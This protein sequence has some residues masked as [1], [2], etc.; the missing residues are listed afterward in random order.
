MRFCMKVGPWTKWAEKYS[1][2]CYLDNRCHG[3]QKTSSEL[4][5][6][7]KG[8]GILTRR[9]LAWKKCCRGCMLPWQPLCCHSAR[10]RHSG[11]LWCHSDILNASPCVSD[12]T[13]LT[14]PSERVKALV[15]L[16]Y[17]YVI[18]LL[19]AHGSWPARK[20][21]SLRCTFIVYMGGL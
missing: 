10:K 13:L 19:H 18:Q 3:N 2:F 7:L 21:L 9:A 12:Y 11:D 6:R 17:L 14:R 4:I 8:Y 1:D 5:K 20:S 15:V 16:V